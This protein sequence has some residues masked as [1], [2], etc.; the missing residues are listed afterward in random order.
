MRLRYK[1]K[2]FLLINILKKQQKSKIISLSKPYLLFTNG[3]KHNKYSD[4]HTKVI[5]MIGYN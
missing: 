2:I 3:F 5:A 1:Q 4:L